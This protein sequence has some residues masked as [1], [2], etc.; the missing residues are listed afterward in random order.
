MPTGF[1]TS[2]GGGAGLAATVAPLGPT[3]LLCAARA[4]NNLLLLSLATT[5]QGDVL[6]SLCW[7]ALFDEGGWYL[8]LAQVLSIINWVP[9]L[10]EAL[11]PKLTRFPHA[12]VTVSR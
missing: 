9:G 3:V 6:V 7:I 4:P 11:L 10:S 2:H 12:W 5:A 1:G 8:Q